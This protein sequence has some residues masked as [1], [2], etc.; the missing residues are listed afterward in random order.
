MH[1]SSEAAVLV[2]A[3]SCHVTPQLEAEPRNDFESLPETFKSVSFVSLTCGGSVALA[4][5]HISF[6]SYSHIFEMFR[7]HEAFGERSL[8]L[9]RASH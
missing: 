6:T 4:W 1:D 2:C 8:F 9:E 3:H 7:T 5:I